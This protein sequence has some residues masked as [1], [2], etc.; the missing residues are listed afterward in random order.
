MWFGYCC[1]TIKDRFHWVLGLSETTY[2]VPGRQNPKQNGKRGCAQIFAHHCESAM[3]TWDGHN[4][5]LRTPIRAFLDSTESSL[6]LE[7]N[8]INFST[9][10]RAKN[11]VWLWTIEEWSVLVFETYVFRTDMNLKCL[12]LRLA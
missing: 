1:V 7:F 6:S 12:G 3:S 2:C 4:F 8:K 5:L 9:K 10:T 11:L